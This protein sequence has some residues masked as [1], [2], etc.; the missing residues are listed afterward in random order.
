[1]NLPVDLPLNQP[2]AQDLTGRVALVTGANTGIG[3]ITARE[4]A[5]RGAEVF[6]ATR[7]LARTQPA[8]DEIAQLTGRPGAH[9][10]EL[11]LADF[12]SVRACAQRFLASGRPLHLLVNN[13]G[14]GGQRGLSRDGLELTFGVNHMGHFLLTELL[15]E[16]LVASAPARVVTVASRAHQWAPGLDWDALRRPTRSLTGIRE[17]MVS[18]LANVLFSAELGRQLAG[19]GVSSYAVHPGVVDT[20]IWRQVPRL[21]RPLLK[22]RGLRDPEQGAQTTLYCALQAPQQETGCYYA[23]SALKSPSKLAQDQRLAAELWRFSEQ[24][25]S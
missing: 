1:M 2:V 11:D 21:L 12:A 4:L 5:R 15:R 10:L 6:L 9:W 20:E 7:S 8:L 22:L 14:L 24:L 3:R 23:D 25:L 19:S 17:Y 13:A 18:K 16:R